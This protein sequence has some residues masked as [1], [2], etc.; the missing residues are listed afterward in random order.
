MSSTELR[1]DLCL[2]L[3]LETSRPRLSCY[4]TFSLFL[5]LTFLSPPCSCSWCHWAASDR[6]DRLLGTVAA[7]CQRIN[8]HPSLAAKDKMWNTIFDHGRL[9]SGGRSQKKKKKYIFRPFFFPPIYVPAWTL[10]GGGM[11]ADSKAKANGSEVGFFVKHTQTSCSVSLVTSAKDKN[12][13]AHVEVGSDKRLTLVSNYLLASWNFSL[14]LEG[15]WSDCRRNIC[16]LSDIVY[17]LT[18]S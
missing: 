18:G 14:P 6:M 9:L 7:L 3:D 13:L 10:N 5:V 17:I 4:W 15:N 12:S 1:K 11:K 16:N 8:L 2:N